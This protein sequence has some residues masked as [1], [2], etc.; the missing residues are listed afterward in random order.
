MGLVTKPYNFSAGATIFA[1][2]HNSDFDTLYNLVNG[3]ITNTNLDAAA[4]IAYTKLNLTGTILNA[5]VNAS[6]AIVDTKLATISTAGKVN[7]SALTVASQ[8]QGDIIYASGT[9]TWA[10]LGPGTAGQV[11]TTGGASANPSWGGAGLTLV[12]NTTVSAAANSGDIAITN[13]N[14]Y[15]A[16]FHF[17]NIQSSL[18]LVLRINNDSGSH[19]NYVY[20]GRTT[21]GAITGGAA[22]T[23]GVSLGSASSA[24]ATRGIDGD[25]DIFPQIGTGAIQ[26]MGRVTYVDSA[27][28]LTTFVDYCGKWDNSAAATSFRFTFNESA[29]FTGNVYLYK[30]ALA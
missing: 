22:G 24:D 6:A 25:L 15:K 5:D 12:S 19:Y 1:A 16:R 23:T 28:T 8:A 29:T 26:V 13:T 18:A 10:R 27:G 14:Y 4:A 21:G 11:L 2:E 9:T 20:D 30:Y 7:I 17:Y 3:S